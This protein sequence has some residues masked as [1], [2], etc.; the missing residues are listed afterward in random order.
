MELGLFLLRRGHCLDSANTMQG[1]RETISGSARRSWRLETV[2]PGVKTHCWG[3]LIGV[4]KQAG[5]NQ[6]L[7]PL[8]F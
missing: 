2:A 5:R 8:A 3:I 6:S 1:C 4:N 7:L